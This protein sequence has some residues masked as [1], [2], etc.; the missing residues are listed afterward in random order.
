METEINGIRLFYED[1]G[2]GKQALLILHGW[3]CD[4]TLFDFI[5]QAFTDDMRIIT[6]D[7][8]GHGRSGE[9]PVPWGVTNF[10]EMVMGL[11]QQ[12]QVAACDV[13][14]H[15]FGGRVAIKLANLYPQLIQHLILTGAA[16]IRKP[17]TAE[18]Q[19]RTRQYRALKQVATALGRLPGFRGIMAK[20][21]DALRKKYGSADYNALTPSMRQT[22]VQIV[23][24]DLTDLL[25][26]VNAPT[27]LLWGDQ[28]TETPI[29]MGQTMEE[30]IPDAALIPFEGCG[31]FAFLQQ[32]DRFITISRHFILGGS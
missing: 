14:A 18:R 17:P 1:T 31:H 19:R 5:V 4:H 9:P 26:N 2:A 23:N 21:I 27:L 8:P 16:G 15:S 10:A 32:T 25:S 22:F 24:E 29:W 11:L 12:L 7:F 20:W 6:L 13:I 28:D 30:K 3:G